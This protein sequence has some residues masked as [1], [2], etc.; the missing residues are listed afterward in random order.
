MSDIVARWRARASRR[1]DGQLAWELEL[2][3]NQALGPGRDTNTVLR[4]YYEMVDL[5]SR[6]EQIP[7]AS[8]TPREFAARLRDLE[9]QS[10][11]IDRLT[12]LFELVRYGHRDSEPLAG[13][14]RASLDEVR[15]D[16]SG[17]ED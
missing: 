13:G 10:E 11:A 14:A 1:G 8:L 3:A 17:A 2:L 5:L 16:A 15:N 7:H 6:K 4:C 9:L 12:R